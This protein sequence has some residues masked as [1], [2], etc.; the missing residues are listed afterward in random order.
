VLAYAGPGSEAWLYFDFASRAPQL[1]QRVRLP[2]APFADR[3]LDLTISDG[4]EA[5]PEHVYRRLF[6]ALPRGR[7]AEIRPLLVAHTD[8]VL[9]WQG[10]YPDDVA[11]L[12]TEQ[13]RTM[14][15]IRVPPPDDTVYLI[16]DVCPVPVAVQRDGAAWRV[17]PEPYLRMRTY[18]P[19]DG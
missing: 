12:L 8:P 18:A 13:A 1:L 14:N 4:A 2:G 17:N 5:G 6:T 10:A 11:D 9:L 3:L 16:S 15:V 7:E 19:A